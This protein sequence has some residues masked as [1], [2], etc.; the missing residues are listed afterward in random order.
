MRLIKK[1]ECRRSPL[2]VSLLREKIRRKKWADLA[3]V[4]GSRGGFRRQRRVDGN[5]EGNGRGPHPTLWAAITH[6]IFAAIFRENPLERLAQGEGEKCPRV[7]RIDEFALNISQT[8]GAA[9]TG[10]KDT[11]ENGNPPP[12]FQLLR[13]ITNPQ[14]PRGTRRGY[15]RATWNERF[16]IIR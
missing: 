7:W 9:R 12:P 13:R 8:A 10:E 6:R 4:A 16:W 2:D 1:R 11:G 15:E 3:R 5:V 14:I